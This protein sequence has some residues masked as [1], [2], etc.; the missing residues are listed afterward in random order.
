M[1]GLFD[2]TPQ[3]FV[4]RG[5]L[6]LDVP[7]TLPLE[8][9]VLAYT[10]SADDRAPGGRS[11]DLGLGIAM[12]D[13]SQSEV[14]VWDAGSGERRLA[15][16][17]NP[18]VIFG[19]VHAGAMQ[20]LRA[21]AGPNAVE[22]LRRIGYNAATRSVF[23]RAGFRDVALDLD[24]HEITAV[25][26]NL[27]PGGIVR[28]HLDYGMG[29]LVAQTPRPEPD[30][31]L[32]LA[33]SEAFPGWPVQFSSGLAGPGMG[34]WHI[35]VPAM[36]DPASLRRVMASLRQGLL[37]LMARHDP[38]RYRA[39]CDTLHGFGERDLLGQVVQSALSSPQAAQ[40]RVH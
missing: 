21:G 18:L 22:L 38:A 8:R 15:R 32:R 37:R 5:Y 36:P 6:P 39:V 16:V 7:P 1:A 2:V 28:V 27:G 13:G 30:P 40:E 34:L 4:R 31:W 23:L 33:L 19:W 12:G 14:P 25:R 20:A 9:A 17:D 26:L 24:P 29:L 35:Q 11:A 3:S 10:V